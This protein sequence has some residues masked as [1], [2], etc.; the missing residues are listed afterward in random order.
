[1]YTHFNGIF[2]MTLVLFMF[3]IYTVFIFKVKVNNEV[4]NFHTHIKHP[5]KYFFPFISLTLKHH[6]N[7]TIPFHIDG[8][9]IDVKMSVLLL[10]SPL[11]NRRSI[12]IN[13][14]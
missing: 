9:K 14:S 13:I 11:I 3:T 1:M 8:C 4:V 12:Y 2:R 5:C 10:N 7:T 6:R